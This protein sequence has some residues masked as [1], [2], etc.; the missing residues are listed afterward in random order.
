[1][2]HSPKKTL[3][4]VD[5]EPDITEMLGEF[6]TDHGFDTLCAGSSAEARTILAKKPAQ[7]VV[8]DIHMPGEDG[9]SLARWLREKHV[10]IGIVMLTTAAAVEDRIAGLEVAADDYVA[11]PFDLRELL[12]RI[13]SVLRR[14]EP[15]PAPPTKAGEV[16]F[17]SAVLN[18]AARKLF[19]SQGTD[20]AITAMEFDLLKVF[21]EHPDQNL[22]R[23]QLMELAHHRGWDVFDRSIDLRVMRLRR[24]IEVDPDKPEVLKTI[25]G[26]G[27]LFVSKV[28]PNGANGST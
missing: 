14:L 25:R 13:N 5:D 21:A 26:V 1:M 2:D 15:A 17:G 6:F 11:K 19:D 8:L 20:L 18:L 3:L 16:R 12:A 27:Y 23:D 22:S 7:L 4:F 10:G 28:N 9:L 24:K